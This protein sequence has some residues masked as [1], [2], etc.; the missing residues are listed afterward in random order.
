M[1]HYLDMTG[2]ERLHGPPLKCSSQSSSEGKS[3]DAVELFSS[4]LEH[5]VLIQ[6]IF[7]ATKPNVRVFDYPG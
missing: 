4:G 3:R 7:R 1:K 2:T 6:R 5:R